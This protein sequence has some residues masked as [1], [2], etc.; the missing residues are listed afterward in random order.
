MPV[1]RAQSQQDAKKRKREAHVGEKHQVSDLED[2][3]PKPAPRKKRNTGP[4]V[5]RKG[6]KSP[7]GKKEVT[8]AKDVA[9]KSPWMPGE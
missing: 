4:K 8:M 3:V 6:T 1:T 9:S 5:D 7:P 2:E